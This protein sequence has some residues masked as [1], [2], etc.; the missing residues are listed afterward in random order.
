MTISK[1]DLSLARPP[2]N[3]WLLSQAWSSTSQ[4]QTSFL[5]PSRP[6]SLAVRPYTPSF[7]NS[8]P[9]FSAYLPFPLGKASSFFDHYPTDSL[10]TLRQLHYPPPPASRQQELICTPR[11]DSDILTLLHQD[12][13]GG[14]EVR[15]ST[16]G[17]IPEPH[18]P[19]SDA[20]QYW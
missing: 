20:C 19:D 12:E 5:P 7:K 3:L 17:W 13:T 18:V 1:S 11:T 14:L 16:G 4:N 8:R 10:S 6:P 9:A 15:D 2:V